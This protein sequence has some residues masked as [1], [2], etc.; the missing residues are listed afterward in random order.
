MTEWW[1]PEDGAWDTKNPNVFYFN[2]TAKFDAPPPAVKASS[3]SVTCVTE[4][5]G[6]VADATQYE[7]QHMLDNMAAANNGKQLI[8]NEDPG[9]TAYLASVYS[10]NL[11]SDKL[12][13]VA[14]HD[15]EPI[16]KRRQPV[17]HH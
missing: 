7:G 4:L 17:P 12:T 16:R 14:E 10:Y 6:K 9:N 11:R 8:L 5:G 2:T 1:R 13:K 3:R 15:P